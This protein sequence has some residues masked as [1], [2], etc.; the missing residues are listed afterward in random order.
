M[1]CREEYEKLDYTVEDLDEGVGAHIGLS[2][3]PAELLMG[4]MRFPSLSLHGI[5]GAYSGPGVKTIIPAK[6]TA[7][8]SIRC[9]GPPHAIS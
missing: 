5:E 1:L 3:N 4:R 8:F 2:D 7:K 9:A 6:V